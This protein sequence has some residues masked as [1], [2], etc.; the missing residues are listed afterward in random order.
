[1]AD[2]AVEAQAKLQQHILQCYRNVFL[3][4]PDGKVVFKDMMKTSGIFSIIGNTDNSELQ[5]RT[6]AQ[7]MVRRII[8]ILSLD[9]ERILNMVL[10]TDEGDEDNG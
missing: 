2:E 4:T 3:H 7:D 5:H 10:E 6:G 9:E 8:G 1:M